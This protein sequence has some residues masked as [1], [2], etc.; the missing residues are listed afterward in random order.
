LSRV[1]RVIFGDD[2][3]DM[4]LAAK[5]EGA[6]CSR[7]RAQSSGAEAIFQLSELFRTSGKGI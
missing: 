1:N 7:N 5:E 4:L 6:G 2:F 3:R